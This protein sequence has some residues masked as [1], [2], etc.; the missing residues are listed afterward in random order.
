MTI[1]A[2]VGRAQYGAFT[3]IAERLLGLRRETLSVSGL[4]IPVLVREPRRNPLVFVHGFGAD[5]EGWLAVIAK[6]PR[7]QGV[8][9][10]DLPGFGEA[11][12]VDRGHSSAMH[13]ARAVKGALDALSV[14]HVT[15]IGASMGGAIS[16]VVASQFPEMT[17][18]VVLLGS[19]G[20]VVDK[21]VFLL[22]LEGGHNPLIPGSYDEFVGMLDFV[23]SKKPWVPRTIGAYLASKQVERK[24]HLTEMFDGW[25]SQDPAEMEALLPRVVAPTLVVHGELDRVIHL[26]TAREIAKRVKTSTLLVLPGVGHVP[27]LEAPTEVAEAIEKHLQQRG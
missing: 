15:I 7:T 8:V 16:L 11:S 18:A 23:T 20:P 10:L 2:S 4:S 1:L 27:Q 14:E 3:S 19:V 9:A 6:L 12:Q 17:R 26:S 13:Q 5:K 25:L 21:S 22:G 24:A